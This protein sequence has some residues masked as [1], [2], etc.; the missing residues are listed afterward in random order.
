MET[1]QELT[2]KNGHKIIH[3]TQAK[4]NKQYMTVFDYSIKHGGTY[5]GFK[6]YN[7]YVIEL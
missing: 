7:D 2:A 4:N 5:N 6:F 1:L 3:Y